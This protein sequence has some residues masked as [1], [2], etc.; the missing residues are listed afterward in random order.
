MLVQHDA[1]RPALFGDASLLED[2]EEHVLLLGVMALVGKLLEEPGCPLRVAFGEWLPRCEPCHGLFEQ[3]Q[4]TLDQVVFGLQALDGFHDVAPAGVAFF[5]SAPRAFYSGS[6]VHGL[7]LRLHLGTFL[8]AHFPAVL[9]VSV[10]LGVPVAVA[11]PVTAEVAGVRFGHAW[12]RYDSFAN[13]PTA[14]FI[15]PGRFGPGSAAR[16]KAM[17]SKLLWIIQPAPATVADLPARYLLP[18][19]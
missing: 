17:A 15:A 16:R 11:H 18:A 9:E 7:G 14:L 13:P 5:R 19:K 8:Y 10:P 12:G 1:N 4:P 2:R 3:A 6:P